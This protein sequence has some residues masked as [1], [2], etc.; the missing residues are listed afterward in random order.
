MRP[1]LLDKPWFPVGQPWGDGT[2]I[3]AGSQEP[4]SGEFVLDCVSPINDGE[5]A[6]DVAAEIAAHLCKLHNT[7]LARR[8]VERRMGVLG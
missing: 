5:R 7:E 2:W 8:L 3:N 6:R 1:A 4:H